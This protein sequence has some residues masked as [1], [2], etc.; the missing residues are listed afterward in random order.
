MSTVAGWPWIARRSPDKT[1]LN[2]ADD[3][4]VMVVPC[5]FKTARDSFQLFGG[6]QENSPGSCSHRS[7]P[8]KSNKTGM[9]DLVT[10]M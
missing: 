9:A 5:L 4:G 6:R 8:F 2:P 3:F 7:P 10:A 1:W